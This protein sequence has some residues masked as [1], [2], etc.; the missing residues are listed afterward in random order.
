PTTPMRRSTPRPA[1]TRHWPRTTASSWTTPFVPFFSQLE[2]AKAQVPRHRGRH[3]QEHDLLADLM[4]AY[5]RLQVVR[6][7]PEPIAFPLLDERHLHRPNP[8]ILEASQRPGRLQQALVAPVDVVH[9]LQAEVVQGQPGDQEV[10]HVLAGD[11]LQRAVRDPALP[12][13]L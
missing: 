8:H 7:S 2:L 12:A 3:V 4:P 13:A 10:V 6:Q 1:P 9:H 5:L 11:L